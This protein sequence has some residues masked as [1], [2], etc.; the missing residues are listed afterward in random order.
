M[1]QAVR[2]SPSVPIADFRDVATVDE[3]I[4]AMRAIDAALPDHDGLKW[5]NFLYLRVSEAVRDDRAGWLDWGYLERFDV[6]FARLYFDA[7]TL[8]E[9]D[10]SLVPRAWQPVFESRRDTRLARVQFAIAGMNAH[11]NRDLPVAL[12]QM[13]DADGAF[14]SRGTPRHADFLRVNALLE[15]VESLVHDQLSVGLVG[16][17]DVALGS[18]D[19]LLAMWKVRRAR[20]AAWTNGEVLWQLRAIGPLQRQFLERLDGMTGFAG[21][22]L[23]LPRLA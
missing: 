1:R 11:I 19:S 16:D 17:L 3:V 4:A 20:D 15:H 13:A 14:V 23:L 8:H 2:Y 6:E 22:G 5:F 10:P 21:R 12:R 18:L 7:V 9:Q